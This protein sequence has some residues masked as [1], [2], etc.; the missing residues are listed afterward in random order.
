[1]KK[2]QI[3]L[4]GK[5]MRFSIGGLSGYLILLTI[6]CSLGNWQLRR[7]EQ[8][9]QFL[10]Q[11]EQ[12]RE[13]RVIDL[14]R[15]EPLDL[16]TLEYKTV[17][18]NGEYDDAHQFLID[19]RVQ[20]GKVGYF[21]MTPFFIAG[22]DR[23]VLV[24]RGWIAM[25]QGRQEIPDISINHR[26]GTIT[27]RVNHFPSVG[28]VLEGADVPSDSWPA[29][30]QV[31]DHEIL[32]EKLDYSLLDFQI[33]LDPAMQDGYRRDWQKVSIMPPEKHIAYAVQWF[34]LALTL[35]VL[36]IGFSLKHDE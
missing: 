31:V 32:A 11:Q 4:A 3:A 26:N 20:N 6:L 19:N 7:A 8:K 15:Q 28:L 9:R 34:A 5:V 10:E 13:T 29:T 30:V 18:V 17:S 22:R 36:F 25:G 12:A 23:A 35:T 24:N 27:G 14:N 16:K 21:V 1:M 33:E 2:I